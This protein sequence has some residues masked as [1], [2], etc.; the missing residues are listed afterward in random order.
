MKLLLVT[1]IEEYEKNVKKILR[2][3][4]VQSF[5]YQEVSG[6]SNGHGQRTSFVSESIPTAS[7]LFTVFIENQCIDELFESFEDFNNKQSVNTKIH[8]ACLDVNRSI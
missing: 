6:Y 8:V 5:S 4:G 3:S 7:L 2:H 1:C